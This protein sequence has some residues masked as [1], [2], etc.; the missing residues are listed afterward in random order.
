MKKLSIICV[1]FI[2]S[3]FAGRLNA[4]ESF[5]GSERFLKINEPYVY[6]WLYS[7][8]MTKSQ[9]LICRLGA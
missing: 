3:I 2:A 4:Q 9:Q 5:S 7:V 8:T 1:C 6:P